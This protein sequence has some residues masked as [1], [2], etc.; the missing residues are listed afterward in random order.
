MKPA[1]ITVFLADDMLIAREGWKRILEGAKDIAIIGEAITA[2]EAPRLVNESMPDILLMDLKWFG[3]ESAGWDA[4]KR[5]KKSN[6]KTKVIAVTAY[7]NLIKDA[8]ANGA[9][10][11]LTKNFTREELTSLIRELAK[12]ETPALPPRDTLPVEE[13]T[14]REVEVLRLA[15][16][17]LRDKQIAETLTVSPATV[18]NHMKSIRAKLGAAN[19]TEAAKVAREKGYTS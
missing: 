13:L 7:E 17:G 2:S 18:K 1:V 14:P 4:I 8:R 19:R 15:A 6:K 11:I 12:I 9:D 16:N 3:D 5:I 10:A